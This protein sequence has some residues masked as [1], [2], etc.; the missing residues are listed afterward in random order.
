MEGIPAHCP[1]CGYVW[2]TRAVGGDAGSNIQIIGGFHRC[3]SCN[4]MANMASGTY[5]MKGGQFTLVNGP[6]LTRM[7]VDRFAEIARQA[8]SSDLS[9]EDVIELVSGVSP[10]LAEKLRGL[11][12]A[13][14]AIVVLLWLIV[15]SCTP[16]L[17]VEVDFNELVDQATAICEDKSE[18]EVM[19]AVQPLLQSRQSGS[20]SGPSVQ[21][22]PGESRQVRRQKE[23]QLKK[24]QKRPWMPRGEL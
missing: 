15:K 1:H 9:T 17:S 4:G 2:Q 13:K 10:E 22:V 18:A 20:S 11:S 24:Q 12:W 7:M 19:E 5:N 3:P 14:L 6:P 21:A 16:S 8:K 23:R